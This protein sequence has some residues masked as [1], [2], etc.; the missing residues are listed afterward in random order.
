MHDQ[1]STTWKIEILY[2]EYR[3]KKSGRIHRNETHQKRIKR[4][5]NAYNRVSKVT[6]LENPRAFRNIV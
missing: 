6:R 2:K 5:G 3:F 1:V 4:L